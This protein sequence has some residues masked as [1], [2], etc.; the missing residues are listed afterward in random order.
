MEFEFQHA[1]HHYLVTY[2]CV[3]MCMC[4]CIY[5]SMY[6]HVCSLSPTT[7]NEG[8]LFTHFRE[9]ETKLKAGKLG[10]LS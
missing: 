1:R 7:A 9:E 10:S 8:L 3:Y 2:A 4:V 6:V 5:V